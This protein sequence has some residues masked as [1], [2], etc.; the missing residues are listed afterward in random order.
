MDFSFQSVKI[1]VHLRTISRLGNV[2]VDDKI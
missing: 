2:C 1:C